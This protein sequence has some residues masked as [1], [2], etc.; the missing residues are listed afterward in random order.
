MGA[1]VGGDAGGTTVGV[2]PGAQWIAVRI[3]DDAGTGTATAIHQGYQ[4]L[5]DPDGNPNTDDAPHI[6]NN[7]WA[8]SGA[9]C[10]LDFEPDLQ[11]LRAAGILPIFAA[12][13][14][15]PSS[16]TSRSPANNPSAFPVGN[17]N[18]TKGIYSSSSRGPSSCAGW[19]GPYPKI[20]APGVTIRTTDRFGGYYN[21]TGTSLSAPHVAGGLAVLLS[22][23]P[24]LSVE[25]QESVLI[26]SAVDL[27]IPGPDNSYG[28]GRLDL[29]AAYNLLTVGTPPTATLTPLPAE[30]ATETFTLTPTLLATATNTETLLPT[31]TSTFTSLPTITQTPTVLPSATNTPTSSPTPSLT[32]IPPTNTFTN[33]PTRTPTR[34]A[35]K[36]PRHTL[37]ATST[38]P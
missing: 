36:R 37:I 6:I 1:M 8:M 23:F 5:L 24:D 27:G 9:G 15:G 34:I 28:Y 16:N 14:Y 21:P 4:W 12:G 31:P 20:V 33:T 18:D 10:N 30:T 19:T 35:T 25:H 29:L 13:N 7:S 2:A 38:G 17:V 11:A 32:T 3:F 26:S 22:V